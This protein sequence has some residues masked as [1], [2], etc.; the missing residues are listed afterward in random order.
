MASKKL[1]SKRNH[2]VVLTGLLDLDDGTVTETVNEADVVYNI[3]E[4]IRAFNGKEVSI[5]VRETN[6]LKRV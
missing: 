5:T 2:T 4:I 1:K 3:N 6:E